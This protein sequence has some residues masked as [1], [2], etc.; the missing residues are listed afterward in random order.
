MNC[1]MTKGKKSSHKFPW[2]SD[3]VVNRQFWL[4]LLGV[5]RGNRR[6]W[7]NDK[8]LNLPVGVFVLNRKHYIYMLIV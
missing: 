8:V 5:G 6:G 4:A 7:L 3:V 1:F 2:G